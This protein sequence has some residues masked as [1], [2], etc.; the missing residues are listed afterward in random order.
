M[1]MVETSALKLHHAPASLNSRRVQMFLAE[2]MRDGRTAEADLLGGDQD[3][4]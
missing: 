2:K 4:H 3:Q 1:I